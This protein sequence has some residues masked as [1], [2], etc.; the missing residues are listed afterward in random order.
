[1]R[2]P[3][4]LQSAL[5]ALQKLPGVGRKSAE[6][7]AFSILDWTSEENRCFVD[8]IE[9]LATS[10]SYCSC[11]GCLLIEEVC[12]FCQD[13]RRDRTTLC[14]IASAREA[15]SIEE[16]HQYRGLY[17]VLGGLISPLEQ[18][19]PEELRMDALKR[20]LQEEE[21][22]EMVIALDSTL[23]GDATALFLR[24]ELAS[25]SI[26]ISRLAFGIPMGSAL[27]YVDG[28]TLARAFSSRTQF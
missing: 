28:G 26:P 9:G 11:C 13:F 24:D 22:H 8:A 2:Y 4:P 5:A 3:K 10:L 15:F 19:G 16:T 21:I 14:I 25:F 20:R 6:R 1:M 17:H 7:F 23:E 12:P 27:E 18:K